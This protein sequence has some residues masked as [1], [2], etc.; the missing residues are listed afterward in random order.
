MTWKRASVENIRPLTRDLAADLAMRVPRRWVQLVTIVTVVALVFAS[1]GAEGSVATTAE[2]VESPQWLLAAV[3]QSTLL[4]SIAVVLL[5][6]TA[7][8]ALATVSCLLIGVLPSAVVGAT[9]RWSAGGAALAALLLVEG[10]LTV[11]RRARVRSVLVREADRVVLPDLHPAARAWV[12]RRGTGWLLLAGLGAL[13]CLGASALVVHDSA[14]AAQFRDRAV[15]GHGEIVEVASDNTSAQ[16]EIEGR[17]YQ[18]PLPSSYPAVGDPVEARYDPASGRAELVD[19]VF[20]PTQAVIPAVLGLA[21]AVV[22]VARTMRRRAGARRLLADGAPAS[23]V[24]ALPAPRAAGAVLTP[25]DDVSWGLATVPA[26]VLVHPI[27]QDGGPDHDEDGDEEMPVPDISAVPDEDLLRWAREGLAGEVAV[28]DP[29]A[30]L[31]MPPDSDVVVVGLTED[32]GPVAVLIDD[33]VWVSG[34]PVAWPGWAWPTRRP[35]HA[36]VLATEQAGLWERFTQAEGRLL[37]GVGRRVG[38]WLPW[39]LLPAVVWASHEAVGDLGSPG[40]MARWVVGL[41]P[42]AW[43]VSFWGE[44]RLRLTADGLRVRGVMM[45]THLPWVRITGIAADSG[46][47]VLRYDDGTPGGDALLLPESTDLPTLGE[48]GGPVALAAR[49]DEQRRAAVGRAP[50]TAP[51]VRERGRGSHGATDLSGR[52]QVRRWPAAP[53]VVAIC[54]TLAWL[55]PLAVG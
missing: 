12:T 55:V 32:G 38:R 44:P 37:A 4:A 19:D 46:A 20:E 3:V 24:H 52:P 17:R 25:W 53:T 33:Q 15:I 6:P 1:I 48:D 8:L 39:L 13:V 49:L 40:E 36:P 51:V 45:T 21:V 28:S 26:L 54:W 47:V 7:G 10:V 34:R 50:A 23:R 29:D 11:R 30:E 2:L 42:V 31:V 18:V 14:A 35:A 5:A 41:A 22:L 43:T 9:G 16:V 27:E